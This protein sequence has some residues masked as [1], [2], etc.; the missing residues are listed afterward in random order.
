[1]RGDRIVVTPPSMSWSP[2]AAPASRPVTRSLTPLKALPSCFVPLDV[3]ASGSPRSHRPVVAVSVALALR[4]HPL[5][6]SKSSKKTVTGV[7][8]VPDG[9]TVTQLLTGPK[10]AADEPAATT[11]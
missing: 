4:V 3:V 5:S 6:V 7:V 10:Q 1:M 9:F 8:P 11:L 2:A